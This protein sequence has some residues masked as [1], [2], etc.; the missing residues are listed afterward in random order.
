MTVRL[1]DSFG[2]GPD[3]TVGIEEELLLVDSVGHALSHS[4]SRVLDAMGM[5]PTRA[6][7]DLYEAQL[8]L[9][10]PPCASSP[11]AAEHLERLRATARSAG[12]TLIGTGLHPGAAFGDV[13]IAEGDRYRRE[14]ENLRG[15]IRRTP[16][17]A[18]HVHVGVPDV[19]T[20]ISVCNGL[21]TLV[22]LLEGLAANSPFWHGL[23]SGLASARWTLRRGYPRVGA[24]PHFRDFEHY[25]L[26]VAQLLAAAEADDYTLIWWEV[27]PH[28]RLGT[29]EVRPMDSQSS[30]DDAAG[31]AALVQSAARHFAEQPPRVG[32]PD[33]VLAEASFRACRDGLGA[34][35]PFGDG[36][37][38]LPAATREV[39]ATVTPHARDLGC[40]DALEQV[41][42]VLRE[43][44]GAD[45]RRAEHRRGGLAAVLEGLVSETG[46]GFRAAR[47]GQP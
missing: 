13:R 10:S 23:D 32:L 42:R 40:E 6:R 22:P 34:T 47:S 9:S 29:V 33:G 26:E 15:V 20:A 24:P 12:A 3:F 8:E 11:E 41:E 31:L 5:D 17:C 28:P 36:L 27:R 38:P 44:N 2:S 4:S 21:R 46:A 16:D 18:L 35:I 45:R 14:A 30:L 37:T 25:S 43:G 1:A 19:E 39:L 7:H